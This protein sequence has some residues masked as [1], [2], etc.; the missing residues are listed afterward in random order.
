MT[1]SLAGRLL[2]EQEIK[3]VNGG[4]VICICFPT[5]CP[6]SDGTYSA[7]DE[8]CAGDGCQSS[9]PTTGAEIGHY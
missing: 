3:S 1:K 8:E 5:L 7:C 9:P 2:S 4:Q 6:N